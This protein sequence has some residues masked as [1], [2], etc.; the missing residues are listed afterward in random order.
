MS[1][2]FV[3]HAPLVLSDPSLCVL[4]AMAAAAA[5]APAAPIAKVRWPK[6]TGM[7]RSVTRDSKGVVIGVDAHS[8][9][10][11]PRDCKTGTPEFKTFRK[12]IWAVVDGKPAKIKRCIVA[13]SLGIITVVIPLPNDEKAHLVVCG[14]FADRSREAQMRNLFPEPVINPLASAHALAMKSLKT[15]PRILSDEE[16]IAEEA[17]AL[18]TLSKLSIADDTI[19]VEEIKKKSALAVAKEEADRMDRLAISAANNGMPIEELLGLKEHDPRMPIS[20]AAA[21]VAEVISASVAASNP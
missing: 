18:S 14:L 7:V 1:F 21:A 12:G 2:L 9:Q 3:A 10:E 5:P 11:Y 17:R 15:R 8:T 20:V 6:K 4:L 19:S 13:L 16:E